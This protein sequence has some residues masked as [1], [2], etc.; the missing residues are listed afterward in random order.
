M[1]C[2][3]NYSGIVIP[4][5]KGTEKGA[6]GKNYFL[7]AK[8]MN[9]WLRKAFGPPTYHFTK[10]QG[11]ANGENFMGLIAG[12]KGIYSMTATG[13]VATGHADLFDGTNCDR[14]C[15]ITKFTSVVDIWELQ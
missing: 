11:G 7:S 5:V 15:D 8:N 13:W 4:L 10:A 2:A 9:A 12:K 3:L 6:D 14:G 1:S